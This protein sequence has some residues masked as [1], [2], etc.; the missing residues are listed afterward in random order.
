MKT[1]II[2]VADSVDDMLAKSNAWYIQHYETYFDN[3]HMVYLRG[4]PHEPIVRGRT[5]LISLGTGRSK[6]D[7]LLAP[8][9]L[10]RYA[11]KIKPTAYITYDQIWSW[12]MSWAMQLFLGA[13][14]YLLPQFMPEQIYK[15]SKKSVSLIFPIWLERALIWLSFF[16]ADRV[17]TGVGLGSYIDW[18][19]STPV[20]KRKTIVAEA[21]VE[22]LPPPAFLENLEALNGFLCPA[23]L[24]KDEG[25]KLIYVGR[26]QR[27]K[28]VDDLI[29]MM[30]LVSEHA[31]GMPPVT[32]TLVGDGPDRESLEKLTDELGVRPFVNFLGQVRN[33]DLPE[34]LLRS[35]VY[36]SPLTG[37]SLRE[38]ALC[39]LP[40]VAYDM[41]WI[42]NL[43]KHEETALLVASGDYNEMGRQVLRLAEDDELRQR[44]AQNIKEF[45]AQ[46]WSLSRVNESMRRVFEEDM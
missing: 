10:Y 30:P 22:A 43:L 18:L 25:F 31:K 2:Y 7:F 14:I 13:R 1:V 44:L 17:L 26:L 45:A 23:R 36:V 4:M 6:L 21:L 29:R 28:L 15:S 35:H 41:D 19:R 8:F 33:E 20:A 11:K 27:Q 3:V 24:A 16:F 40:M 38:A 37:M 34:H 9:R 32:L 5:A 46:I 12:W 42:Q 39:G